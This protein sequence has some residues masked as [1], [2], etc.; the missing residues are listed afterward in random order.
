VI[1][2][3]SRGLVG[4]KLN[5]SHIKKLALAVVHA[6]QCFH[7]Y[8]L[9]HKTT[10]IAVVNPFQYMLTRWVIGENI[11]RWIVVLQEFDLDFISAKSK[12]S[13]VFAEL[14]SELPIESGDFVPEE[15]PI[16]GDM[17]LITSLDPL[18]GDTLIYLQ[19][20][21][22][23]TSASRDER[24]HIRHQTKNY[25]ILDDTL[26]QRSVDCILR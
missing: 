7:H 26:Y 5:Y 2:F 17:F 14:I 22:C 16:R 13:L 8:V 23:P 18:H 19:T 9:F 3:L 24:R 12:K 20:L 25:L 1:Y 15:S 10:V 6:V 4:L 21:K 11:S